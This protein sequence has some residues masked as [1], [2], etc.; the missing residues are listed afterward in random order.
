VDE[1]LKMMASVC[2][3]GAHVVGP[4]LKEMA[5]LAHTE[6]LLEGQSSRDVR[7]LIRETMFAPTVTGSPLENACRVIAKYEP[8]GRG[9]YSGAVAL[10]SRDAAGGRVLDC[11]IFIRTADILHDGTLRLGLGATLV[12]HSDPWSEV[13]ETRVKAA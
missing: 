8:T 1:E 2:D 6:Y 5:R 3:S 7:D 10:V 12:R 4:Y 9:Y 11:S 13:A